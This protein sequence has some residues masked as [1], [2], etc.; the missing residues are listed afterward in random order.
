MQVKLPFDRQSLVWRKVW[1]R[2]SYV[3]AYCLASVSYN[4][5]KYYR[6]KS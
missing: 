3:S 6:K 1:K 4:I 2:I 5:I